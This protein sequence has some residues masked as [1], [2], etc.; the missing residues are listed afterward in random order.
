MAARKLETRSLSAF[1]VL[2]LALAVLGAASMLYY[3]LGLFM[4]RVGESAGGKRVGEGSIRSATIST[5]SG[6]LR[7]NGFAKVAIPYSPAMTREI[8]IGL[9]GRPLDSQY[10]SDRPSRLSH[11]RL[12]GLHADLLFWPAS[13]I[14]ISHF[15]SCVWLSVCAGRVDRR[16]SVPIASVV[17]GECAE[18]RWRSRNPFDRV[19]LPALEGLL[20]RAVGAS[21]WDFSWPPLSSGCTRN[22]QLL[23]GTL[24]AI[25]YHQAADGPACAVISVHLERERLAWAW[26]FYCGFSRDHVHADWCVPH[27]LAPMDPVLD[28]HRSWATALHPAPSCSGDT[29]AEPWDGKSAPL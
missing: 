13:E 7:V 9:L 24:M 16:V 8:Q 22:R 25:D 5:Q 26:P 12:S 28:E 3:H 29:R 27:S 6:S 17:A 15:P 1:E 19:Q 20:C 10:P 4:P 11:V 23:A 2:C 18:F 14:P 21:S